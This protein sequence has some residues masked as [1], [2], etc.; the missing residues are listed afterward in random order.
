MV[1]VVIVRRHLAVAVACMA[2]GACTGDRSDPT[3]T[4]T[5]P[6]PT[7]AEPT[8]TGVPVITAGAIPRL[9]PSGV[10]D[11]LRAIGFTTAEP[12][13]IGSS[14]VTTTSRRSDATV[15]TYGRTPTEV[16]KVVAEAERPVAATVLAVVAASPL[17]GAE[18]ARAQTWLTAGLKQP[19]V[20]TSKS[21]A[22]PVTSQPQVTKATFGGQPYELVVTAATATLSIGRIT[23]A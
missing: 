22:A 17:Q 16:V 19:P 11:R 13:T 1:T 4:S 2:L 23:T 12:T 3:P 21:L 18:V 6:A 20:R 7:T 9:A 10:H 8:T 5:G 15:S 14:F